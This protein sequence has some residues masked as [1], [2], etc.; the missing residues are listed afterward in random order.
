[1]KPTYAQLEQAIENV[2]A[3]CA[4]S[5]SFMGV[6][7]PYTGK[8]K[9]DMI[10]VWA[11]E[12]ALSKVIP[13]AVCRGCGLTETEESSVI[14]RRHGGIRCNSCARDYESPDRVASLE[15]QVR[16]QKTMNW[17]ERSNSAIAI[18]RLAAMGIRTPKLS[19][20]V[21]RAIQILEDAEVT[22]IWAGDRAL[23]VLR[24]AK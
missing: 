18:E 21:D 5:S 12:E 10:A 15:A 9:T 7:I 16:H 13:E 6:P 3:V 11:I 14:M 4:P 22:D 17:T 19:Q 1:M 20:A 24:G 8:S 2:R 23:E